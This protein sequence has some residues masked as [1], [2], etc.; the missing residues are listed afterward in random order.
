MVGITLVVAAAVAAFL[1][2]KHQAQS[3]GEAVAPPATGLPNTPDYHSLLVDPADPERVVLGTHAGLYEST[4]GGRS[5]TAAGLQGMDA[6]NLV[7]PTDGVIWAAG[8]NALTRSDDGGNTWTDVRPSGLPSLDVHGFARDPND[9]NRLFAAVAGEGLYGSR[10]G[11]Q[12]FELVSKE[13]GPA[14]FGLAVTP[15]GRI[16]AGDTSVGL[17]ASDDGGKSWR[18]VEP[19]AIFGLAVNPGKPDV[20]A[21]AGQGSF[22]SGILVSR[23]GGETWDQAVSI[24][25]GAGPVA[26]APSDADVGYA[27]GFDRRVYRTDDGG[28]SWKPV[29]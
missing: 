23:D 13:V 9:A 20:I 12:S 22:F 29:E 11:G 15:T 7:R 25:Q 26:W 14:V 24:E 18:L 21:A 1:V 16:L 8:H 2:A 4:N 6:M 28:A 5:W 27:V 17:L 3:P 10:D 19:M